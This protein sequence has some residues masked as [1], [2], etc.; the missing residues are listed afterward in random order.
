MKVLLI[1]VGILCI[2]APLSLTIKDYVSHQDMVS[3]EATV[4]TASC[5]KVKPHLCSAIVNYAYEN[6]A[7]S[8][9]TRTRK[10]F[11]AGDQVTVRLDP[12][13]PSEPNVD[14]FSPLSV[15]LSIG[16]GILFIA[17]AYGKRRKP[18][19]IEAETR[20]MLGENEPVPTENGEPAKTD[21]A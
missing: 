18:E 14:E 12:A 16:I 8:T 2:I 6:N 5:T 3:V 7:Y 10:A 21:A 17:V 4:Q 20:R 13:N 15:G 9:T 19:E 1:I 11:N